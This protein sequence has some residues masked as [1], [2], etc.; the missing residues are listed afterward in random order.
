MEISVASPQPQAQAQAQAQVAVEVPV[1]QAPEAAA[2][3]VTEEAKTEEHRKNDEY[4]LASKFAALSRRERAALEREQQLKQNW[5]EYQQFLKL[6]ESAKANPLDYLQ[7]AGLDYSYVTEHLLNDGK[8]STERQ[9]EALKAE[10]ERDRKA[11]QEEA[12]KA[13][14]LEEQRVIEGHKYQIKNFVES[15]PDE[16]ELIAANEAHD[17][18][19]ETIEQHFMKTG[20]LLTIQDAAMAVEDHLYQQAQRLLKLKK[21]A[22]KVEPTEG[23]VQ[24]LMKEASPQPVS[25]PQAPRTLTASAASSVSPAA[26]SWLSDEESKLRAAEL[27]KWT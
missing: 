4:D 14:Q 12:L 1:G 8:P 6:K 15:N 10:I 13:Q 24:E 2:S 22:P 5:D 16:Y 19:F 27:L 17:V 9:L 21:F 23:A 11:R 26:P 25:T 3:E 20:Q 7:A 18:V